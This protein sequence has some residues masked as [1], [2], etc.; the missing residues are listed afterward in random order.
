MIDIETKIRQTR[1][2][3]YLTAIVIFFS[4]FTTIFL[5]TSYSKLESYAKH[6]LNRWDIH[7]QSV[8]RVEDL[9][10]AYYHGIIKVLVYKA[11]VKNDLDEL[12]DLE[13]D[14][15]NEVNNLCSKDIFTIKSADELF[16]DFNCEEFKSNI[17]ILENTKKAL[18]TAF[19]EGDR[20]SSSWIHLLELVFEDIEETIDRLSTYSKVAVEMTILKTKKETRALFFSLVAMVVIAVLATASYL[21][22]SKKSLKSIKM[23]FKEVKKKN[24]ELQKFNQT[25]EK[26]VEKR[27]KQLKDANL[28]LEIT[29][30]YD[31]KQQKLAREKQEFIIVNDIKD[32]EKWKSRVVYKPSDILSGDGYSIF[33]NYKNDL[34]YFIIDGQGHGLLPSLTVF[35]VA[36]TIRQYINTAKDLQEMTK[37]IIETL[38]V[39]LGDYEQLSYT[40]IWIHNGS[41]RIEYAIGGMYETIVKLQEKEVTLESNNIPAMNFMDTIKVDTIDMRGFQSIITYSDGLVE[42][43]KIPKYFAPEKLI[44]DPSLI[45]GVSGFLKYRKPEDDVTVVF[46]EKLL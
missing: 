6:T 34:I 3:F 13:R 27:T 31:V 14:L 46:I 21:I 25:L 44:N 23:L 20:E 38:K 11:E 2:Y 19:L 37:H 15:N 1:K 28:E 45:I 24:F 33:K 16:L 17:T 42:D 26:K 43:P 10:F 18:T 4:V 30:D 40:I 22:F 29:R 36:S 35:A 12:Q 32:D 39:V 41:K 8:K 5:L 9:T 7:H